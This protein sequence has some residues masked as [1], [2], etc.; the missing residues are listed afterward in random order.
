MADYS[1]VCVRP[2]QKPQRT[3]AY[4]GNIKEYAIVDRKGCL[5]DSLRGDV[6]GKPIKG[7][8]GGIGPEENMCS[9][10]LTAVK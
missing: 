8:S 1:P 3:G 7:G 4:L 2:D 10:Y 9:I 5:G 6:R